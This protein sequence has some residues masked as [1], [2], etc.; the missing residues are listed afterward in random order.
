MVIASIWQDTYY[1]SNEKKITYY[2]KDGNNETLFAG[3]AYRFPDSDELRINVSSICRNYMSNDLRQILD[4]YLEDGTTEGESD[5]GIMTFYLYNAEDDTVLEIFKFLYDWSYETR[6]NGNDIVLSK[7]INGRATNIMFRPN[8]QVT[9]QVMTNS[10]FGGDYE[11]VEGCNNDYAIYYLNSYGGHDAF[12]FEGYSTKEDTITQFTTDKSFN[13]Q[14]L[15]YEHCRYVSEISTSYTLH[16]GWLTDEQSSNFAKNLV[17]SN[18]VYL[19]DLK[20]NDIIPAVITDTKVQYKKMKTNG[21][22]MSLYTLQIK[23]SQNKLR[24]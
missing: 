4:I 8:T 23:E 16:T 9:G 18:Q 24:R 15:D 19:H 10:L 12:L 13:N 20:T 7:P 2:I 11:I 21:G 5:E 22:K 14:T 6:W 1:V 3:K 17:G